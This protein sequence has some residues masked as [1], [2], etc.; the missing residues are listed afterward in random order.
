[1]YC[2]LLNNFEKE[3]KLKC[4][5]EIEN[6]ISKSVDFLIKSHEYQDQEIYKLREECCISQSNS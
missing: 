1:M 5:K 2:Y 6:K 3:F 4:K